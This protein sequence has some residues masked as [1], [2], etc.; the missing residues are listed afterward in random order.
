MGRGTVPAPWTYLD[1]LA[2]RIVS[3]NQLEHGFEAREQ[4]TGSNRNLITNEM[5]PR[6]K[7]AL[8]LS[9]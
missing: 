3:V 6:F 2:D 7:V 4:A 5:K 9:F 1:S 8:T